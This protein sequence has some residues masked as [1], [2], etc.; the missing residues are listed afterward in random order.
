MAQP[1]NLTA[2]LNVTGPVG[3][4]PVVNTIR[5]QLAGINT[6]VNVQISQQSAR[7][8]KNLNSQ[9]LA[10]NK[11]LQTANGSAASL[12]A[13]MASLGKSVSNLGGSSGKASKGLSNDDSRNMGNMAG[14]FNESNYQSEIDTWETNWA[15]DTIDRI[16]C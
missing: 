3:L 13:Q 10:L 2:Q 14:T 9:I 8:V 16:E 6:N 12:N 4:R 1:F 11:S 5:K 7:H 15:D